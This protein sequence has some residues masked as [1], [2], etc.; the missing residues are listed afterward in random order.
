MIDWTKPRAMSITSATT[1]EKAKYQSPA[2]IAR[3]QEQTQAIKASLE[4][5]PRCYVKED[6]EIGEGGDYYLYTFVDGSQMCLSDPYD[7]FITERRAVYDLNT[8]RLLT[9]KFHARE[10]KKKKQKQSK[11]ILYSV[12]G[13]AAFGLLIR[14]AQK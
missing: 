4:N 7:V 13:A 8:K 2:E 14:K 6:G 1:Q 11:I 10:E 9:A 3:I 12:L 5:L